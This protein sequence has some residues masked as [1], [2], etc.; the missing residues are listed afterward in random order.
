[1][2]WVFVW[3][4]KRACAV[5]CLPRSSGDR[6][7]QLSGPQGS[8]PLMC[9]SR[10]TVPFCAP[11]PN[12]KLCFHQL[13]I[14]TDGTYLDFGYLPLIGVGMIHCTLWINNLMRWLQL[15]KRTLLMFHEICLEMLYIICAGPC[16][17]NACF[18]VFLLEY[19]VAVFHISKY[20]NSVVTGCH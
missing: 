9:R 20:R 10:S 8:L 14:S 13:H 7:Y 19:R 6:R 16:V 4:L 17:F 3:A 12:L 18:E 11:N 1:M 2:L 5:K 15:E